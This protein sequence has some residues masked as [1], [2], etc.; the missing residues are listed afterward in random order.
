MRRIIGGLALLIAGCQPAAPTGDPGE[1]PLGGCAEL[2]YHGACQGDL[3]VWCDNG[4]ERR[5]D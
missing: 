5:I 4:V 1:A 2:G 3:A